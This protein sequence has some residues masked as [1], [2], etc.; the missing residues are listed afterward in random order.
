MPASTE[1]R[2]AIA[3]C[4]LATPGEYHSV[5]HLFGVAR[6]T[7]CVIVNETCRTILFPMY[8]C[9]PSGN[10]LKEVVRGFKD[11]LG[12]PQCAGSILEKSPCLQDQKWQSS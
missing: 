6:C 5:A 8:V 7:V 11:K 12:V 10:G 3:L 4:V 1:D 2:V 9:F